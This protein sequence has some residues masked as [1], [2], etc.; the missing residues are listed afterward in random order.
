VTAAPGAPRFWRG[1]PFNSHSGT[2]RRCS[3]IGLSPLLLSARA[4]ISCS[5]DPL[6]S[7]CALPSILVRSRTNFFKHLLC[8][9]HF[10]SLSPWSDTEPD[11]FRPRERAKLPNELAKIRQCGEAPL[12]WPLRLSAMVALFLQAGSS[13][14]PGEGAKKPRRQEAIRVLSCF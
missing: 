11:H 13:G 14:Q 2:N 3:S 6:Q 7:S 4:P 9:K 10:K 5:D 12:T 1:A 8:H